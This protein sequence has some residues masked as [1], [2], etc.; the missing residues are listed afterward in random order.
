MQLTAGKNVSLAA[1]VSSTAA[2]T[3]NFGQSIAGTFST[4]AAITGTPVTINGG[5][6]N[7]TFDFSGAPAITATLAGGGA[8][9]TLKGRNV[10]NAWTISGPNAGSVGGLTFTAMTN[11]TGGTSTDTLT[12]VAGGA[13]GTLPERIPS[14]SRG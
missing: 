4:T 7:D 14:R 12:G 11:L 9:D 8:S 13:T 5:A 10:A 1:A 2:T 3:I 6:F